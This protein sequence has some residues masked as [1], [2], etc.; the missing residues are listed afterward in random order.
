MHSY[1]FGLRLSTIAFS[2]TV[3]IGCMVGPN[4]RSPPLPPVTSYTKSPLPKKTVRIYEA[5]KAGKAQYL[6]SGQ[7]IPAEWWMLFHSKEVNKLVECGLANSPNLA[8]AEATLK[9]AQETLNAQIGNLLFPAV[10]A[11]V[12]GMRQRFSEST[13]GGG[14]NSNLFNLF[15]ASIN[16]SYTLDV[17]GGSRRQIEA[18]CAQVDYNHY[19]LIASYLSLTSNIV[20][21]AVTIASLQAQITATQHLIDA[22]KKQLVIIEKQLQLGGVSSENVLSQ[23][24]LLAQ[25]RALLPPLEKNLAQSRHA[26]AVLIGFFPSQSELPKINLDKLNLPAHL[27]LSLPS[28]L[29]CQRPDVQAQEALLHA[30]SAQIGVATANLFPQFTLTGNYGWISTVPNQLLS[31][32]TNTW[33]YGG[34]L[35]QPLFK[36]GSLL[37]QRRAAIDAYVAADAKYRQ[38]VLQ[39]FQNVADSLHALHDDARAFRAQKQ[40]E[41]AALRTFNLTQKQYRLGATS[42]LSLLNAEEKYQQTTINRIQ[43]QAARYTDTVALFQSLGGGWWNRECI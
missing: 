6:L 3:L 30:A 42:Y 13:I 17:F 9:Q 40:A 28:K 1:W 34:Q 20:T 21:T 41:V 36:G 25:T 33:A 32:T 26:L 43:A 22:E 14:N 16:V 35:L 39:A 29:V 12:G 15:N 27:P 38:T 23:Q 10:T 18:L 7:D 19:L 31:I 24:T 11:Q 37:A 4:F 8:A 2:S 5:G